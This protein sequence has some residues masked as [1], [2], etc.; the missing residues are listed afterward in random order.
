MPM[1]CPGG[2]YEVRR[3]TVRYACRSASTRSRNVIPVSSRKTGR[4]VRRPSRVGNQFSVSDSEVLCY[5][6]AQMWGA[7]SWTARFLVLVMLVSSFGP[8][9]M[10]CAGPLGA[11][12]CMRKPVSGPPTQPAM[13]CHHAMA[14][15]KAPQ[16][17]S[18]KVGSSEASFQAS[19]DDDCCKNHCC[20][21]ATTSE[22]ARPASNLLGF[23]SLLIEPA[24]PSQS[25]VLQSI[26]ISGYDSARAPPRS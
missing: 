20:C 10:A 17:E 2:K 5:A 24:S 15:S 1:N 8:L 25:A 21:G 11:M 23:L 14:Q 13:P 4:N 12:H 26:D 6:V 22:W 19:D 18:S 7:S 9:T 3:P 16:S